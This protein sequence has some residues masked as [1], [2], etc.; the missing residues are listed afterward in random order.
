MEVWQRDAKCECAECR[1]V[2][3]MVRCGWRFRRP[4]RR[5]LSRP[6]TGHGHAQQTDNRQRQTIIATT[7]EK[8]GEWQQH[9]AC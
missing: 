9:N 1:V 8:V 2:V 5:R 6:V 7:G 4:L 3:T